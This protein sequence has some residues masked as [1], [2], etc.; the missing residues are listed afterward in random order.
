MMLLSESLNLSSNDWVLLILIFLGFLTLLMKKVDP[1]QFDFL[2]NPFK[3]KLY[4]QRYL[5][6]R[7]FKIFDKFYLINYLWILMSISL[8]FCFCKKYL[9][10]KPFLIY[11]YISILYFLSVFMFFRKIVNYL[12]IKINKNITI[13]K[14]YWFQS[15]IF[16]SY[17][18]FFLIIITTSLELNNILTL[19]NFKFILIASFSSLIYFNLYFIIGVIKNS[20]KN[21]IYL[22]YY[23]CALKLL[24]WVLLANFYL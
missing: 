10:L 24:P 21:F 9:F 13:L 17:M 6:D 22:F 2:K 11:D 19:K 1:I 7:N 16:L 15:T 12:I 14:K 4:Y 8:F 18:N 20:T 5:I 23:I 3:H